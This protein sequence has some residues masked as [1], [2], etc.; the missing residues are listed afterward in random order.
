MTHQA[1]LKW[2]YMF[3]IKCRLCSTMHTEEYI[4][5]WLPRKIY[6]VLIGHYLHDYKTKP[7]P[8]KL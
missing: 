8:T 6:F 3:N 5:N 2:A 4:V 7:Q 1:N